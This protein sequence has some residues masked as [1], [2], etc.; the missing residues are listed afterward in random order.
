MCRVTG[1]CQ[2]ARQRDVVSLGSLK[3]WKKRKDPRTVQVVRPDSTG[4]TSDSLLWPLSEC[5]IASEWDAAPTRRTPAISSHSVTRESPPLHASR[6]CFFP[7]ELLSLSRLPPVWGDP[8]PPC[9]SSVLCPPPSH[10]CSCPPAVPSTNR[11]PCLLPRPPPLSKGISVGKTQPFLL[12]PAFSLT[13]SPVWG[14][15]NG[16]TLERRSCR[17]LT[18]RG[19]SGA[20]LL[21]M[22]MAK[23]V[24]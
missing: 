10:T 15:V 16:Q 20:R 23:G 5:L 1:L 17:R 12:P 4:L 21:G 19:R 9:W 24:P 2:H 11:G 22:P 14:N 6:P 3:H 7:G 13:G 18:A 8:T